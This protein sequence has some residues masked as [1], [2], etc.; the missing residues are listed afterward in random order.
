M[1][2][3]DLTV[4]DNYLTLQENLKDLIKGYGISVTHLCKKT[5]ISRSTFDRKMKQAAF[6]ALEMKK[7]CDVIN[8]E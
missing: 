3:I 1:A 8:G 4:V 6:S 5:S 7:I 2:K